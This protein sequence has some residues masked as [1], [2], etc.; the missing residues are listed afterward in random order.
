MHRVPDFRHAERTRQI[1]RGWLGLS[2]ADV[3]G[4]FY[5]L[6]E[7]DMIGYMQETVLLARPPVFIS[8]AT[9]AVHLQHS[10]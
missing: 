7:A 8:A 3:W 2:A 1:T 9:R 6:Y 5:D 10:I 4:T